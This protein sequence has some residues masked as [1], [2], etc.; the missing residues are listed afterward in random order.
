M[1]R[2]LALVLAL[3]VAAGA[4]A[5][6]RKGQPT[7]CEAG[8]C[9][10]SA[11]HAPMAAVSKR[12]SRPLCGTPEEATLRKLPDVLPECE[13]DP[14]YWRYGVNGHDVVVVLASK[15]DDDG[16]WSQPIIFIDSKLY[17]GGPPTPPFWTQLGSLAML[18]EEAAHALLESIVAGNPNVR[19][20]STALTVGELES[21]LAKWPA[22]TDAMRIT[23][24]DPPAFGW[25][26]RGWRIRAWQFLQPIN[27]GAGFQCPLASRAEYFLTDGA[28]QLRPVEN[29][30]LATTVEGKP[31][32]Q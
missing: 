30:A 17:G 6:N 32:S 1:S 25:D 7:A 31:C 13:R 3:T 2:T 4:A 8:T 14:R 9:A 23:R 21:E 28:L 26:G 15:L 18:E 5:C 12:M 20:S 22:A 10:G 24:A 29:F 27:T 19:F 16:R 11:T